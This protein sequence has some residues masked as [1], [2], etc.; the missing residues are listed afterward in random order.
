MRKLQN[1]KKIRK[2]EEK[3]INRI[4]HVDGKAGRSIRKHHT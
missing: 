4:I 2:E 3:M 1:G